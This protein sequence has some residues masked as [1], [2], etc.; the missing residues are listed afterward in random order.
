MSEQ[1]PPSSPEAGRRRSSFTE[2]FNPRP[3]PGAH[4]TSYSP[5]NIN[6][7]T[8]MGNPQSNRR[9]MSITTL[10]LNGSSPNSQNSPLSAFARQR[11]ASVASS[12]AS[13]SPE[14]KNSFEDSAVMEEDH[15]T[16]APPITPATPSFARRVSFGAQALRD[17]RSTGTASGGRRPSLFAT[18]QEQPENETPRNDLSPSNSKATARGG[19]R[20]LFLSCPVRHVTF[21]LE[22]LEPLTFTIP[23]LNTDSCIGEG[24][25]WSEAL[26]DRTKRQS[27]VSGGGKPFSVRPRATSVATEEPPKEM[28]RAHAP[29]VTA[30]LGKPDQLGE[31]MLRG[32]FMMD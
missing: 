10:G 4:S 3:S 29:P 7:S 2:L 8:P 23:P 1:S 6:T 20:G 27:S 24:F 31:R 16:G 26:R 13:G 11:R 14:F 32:D 22:S 30:R 25:N 28:P 19:S 21:G 9:G 5:P 12:S 17:V 15:Q 18:L